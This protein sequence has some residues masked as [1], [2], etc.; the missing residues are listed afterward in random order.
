M[1]LESLAGAWDSAAE[2]LRRDN[3]AITSLLASALDALDNLP[4]SSGLG[5]EI[6]ATLAAPPDERILLSVLTLRS[7]T[8]RAALERLIV[9]LEDSDAS[10]LSEP[11]AQLRRDI[12]Q[13]LRSVAARGWSFW[14][15][16]SFRERMAAVRA[17]PH[18][19]TP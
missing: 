11:L 14:D 8:L 1:L 13:H 15:V 9:S 5:S 10:Q 18:D 3:V 17:A 6:R 16:S 4:K 19:V 7:Q 12:Y 2:D